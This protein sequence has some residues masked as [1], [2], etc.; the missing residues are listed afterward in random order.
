MK[1]F[2]CDHCGNII[3]FMENKGVPVMCCGQKMTELVPGSVDAAA[4]TVDGAR[5]TVKVGE[6]DHPMTEPHHIGWIVLETSH[7]FM[8][9]DLEP[10]GA[11]VAVFDL[12]DDTPVAVY[13][14][15]NLHGLWK[16]EL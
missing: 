4:E 9:R 3:A 12:A 5:V 14:W 8:K 16:K 1:F 15:C 10:T 6:I 7:G 11:P 2:R 13:A